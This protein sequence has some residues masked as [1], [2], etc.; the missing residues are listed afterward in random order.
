MISGFDIVNV[1]S[2]L[3]TPEWMV[4]IAE[5]YPQLGAN[6]RIFVKHTNRFDHFLAKLTW[7][8][9]IFS[10]VTMLTCA[11][12]DKLNIMIFQLLSSSHNSH[13]K[14]Y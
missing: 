13:L 2:A 7:Y 6:K 3:S 1:A 4:R 10:V 5:R 14:M 8:S 11:L 12:L 9:L